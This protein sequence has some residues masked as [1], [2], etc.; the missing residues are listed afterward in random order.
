MYKKVDT[1]LNFV[2]RELEVLKFWKENNIFEQSIDQ[3]TDGPTFTF[4]DGPPTANGK[5]HIGHILTR[6]IKDLIPRYKA[7]KG[8]HVLRKAGWDTHGLPVELEVEKVL[9]I[10]GKPQIE[11]YGVEKFITQ[12]K[13][14]VWKYQ[15]EWEKM[16]DRVG[17]WVDM[18]NPYVTYHNNYIE[19]VWWSLR[20][21][22]NKDLIYKG[23]KIVPYCPRC[24]TSLSS[25]EVA[26]GYKDVK[27][28]TAIAKFKVAGEENT[29]LL[30]WTTTPWTLPSNVALCVNPESTYVKAE[31][32]GT[33]YILAEALVA[34]VLDAETTTVLETYVGKDLCGMTYEPLFDFATPDKKAYF[35]V[36]DKYVT[37]TDGT[38]IV[39][40]A[41]AF[42][43]D[44]ARIGRENDLPFV[45]L[46]NEQ[47]H[48]TPEV[49]PWQDIF[50]KDADK[51]II[52]WLDENNKLFKS[53]P[54]EHSYPHCWR[55]DTPL[56]Y[57]ARDTWFIS[58]SKVRAALVKNNNTVNWLPPAIGEGRFGNFLEGVIDWGLSRSRYWGTPLPI[59]EC[60]CGHTHLIGSIEELKSMSSDCPDDIE[61]HKPYID[62]VH[63]NCPKCHN[64]MTRVEDVIDCWYDSGSMPFAQ[65]H[66]P[67]ENKEIFDQNY[68]ADFISE[69]VDQTRGWFYTLMAI[70]TLIFD[71]SPYK[72]VVVLGHVGDKDGIKM[73]KHKGNV[74]DPWTVLDA[75]GA[76]AVRWYFYSASAPWL[77]SRF[78]NENVSE[79]QRKFIGTFWNTY[80]FYVLY[81]NIDEFNPI[82][83]TLDYDSLNMMDKWVLSKLNTLVKDV[84]DHLDNYRIFEA[85]RMMQDF[86]DDVSNWYVRRSRERFW[87]SDMP[88]DKVNAYMTLY[89]VLSTLS[90]VAAPFVPFMSD[91]I[92]KNL[93]RTNDESAPISV[94]LCDFPVANE[95]MID[96]ELEKYMDQVLQ[97]VVLGR[98]C[99][100]ESNIKNR[101]PVGTM[102]VGATESLPEAFASIVA[103]ELNIKH[104]EF[105]SDASEFISY[106]FK[107]QM[108]TLGPKYGKQLNAIRT[109]LTELDGS[110]A[111]TELD[112]TGT[113]KLAID[114]ETIALTKEDLLIST[115][116][117]DGFMAQSEGGFTVVLDTNLTEELL[118]EGFVR[119]IISKIQT[120]RKEANFEVQDHILVTYKD[121][122][123]IAEIMTRNNAEIASDV[124]ANAVTEGDLADGYTKAW[125]VNG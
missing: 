58:M 68:P 106:T 33:K 43:E 34:S 59:W 125:K 35:V 29:Y 36:A 70:S 93:V 8:Y 54:H 14:S 26:Q 116:Q 49:T 25:H 79:A 53:A 24:G 52:K 19:S 28:A 31:M 6:V 75:Q 72:N 20:E 11:E 95:S 90:K 98:A 89:T 27:D 64:T 88:Q 16:S 18:E 22:W 2:D 109:A 108:R 62:N 92:Y 66:Y 60:S 119:E 124:L 61:L 5:P 94:H 91:E 63:L 12:C 44:D 105:T 100:N 47:G 23:H 115:A 103:E 73:S 4:Y 10:S 39:H 104:V 122:A 30:A 123:K 113:L 99:R 42:G 41:P 32:N 17:Y 84:D 15:S 40:I 3:R 87:Q 78:G 65:L 102:Y 1:N 97:I 112:E 51:L 45:Q 56:L 83:Y 81:A 120:M 121:N 9:G 48:F 37:L 96:S 21:I 114:G 111:M 57:Y 38:G 117:K 55:C 50:V 80:A 76:D 71:K 74:V 86:I 13:E 46:V 82:N 85:S 101:Q 107:P 67:F 7:M 110:A 77:P 69:A 118:E